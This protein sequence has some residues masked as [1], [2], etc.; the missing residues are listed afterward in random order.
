MELLLKNIMEDI[1]IKRID[2]IL[3]ELNCCQCDQCRLDIASYSLN[4][5]PPKY[6]ITTQGELLSKLDVLSTQF[7]ASVIAQITQASLQVAH[8]P[9]H[10]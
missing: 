8:H 2:E 10:N 1:V 5:L 9:R 6:V 7:E 3:P 4:R